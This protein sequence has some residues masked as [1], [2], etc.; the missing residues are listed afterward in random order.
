MDHLSKLAEGWGRMMEEAGGIPPSKIK[1]SARKVP[2]TDEV[3]QV[4]VHVP[5]GTVDIQRVDPNRERQCVLMEQARLFRC[6]R[7]S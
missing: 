3:V 2:L 5:L 6:S 1:D 4:L 7:L